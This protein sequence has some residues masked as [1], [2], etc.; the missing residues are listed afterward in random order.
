MISGPLQSAN[1]K[2]RFVKRKPKKQPTSE[3]RTFIKDTGAKCWRCGRTKQDRP[4]F[5]HAVF[6][7]ERAHID[8]CNKPR[9]LDRRAVLSL[10]S[11]CHR[12]QHGD[13]FPYDTTSGGRFPLCTP[14]PLALEELL[15]MTRDRDPEYF[16]LEFLQKCSI[17]RLPE[18]PG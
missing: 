10:C 8:G 18:I 17:K 6:L 13:H 11:I 12:I 1:M 14:V 2:E 4:K 15:Q 5:W 9:R 3:Y 7:T 16:D